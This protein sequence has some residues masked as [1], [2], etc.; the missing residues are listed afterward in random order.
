MSDIFDVLHR[1]LVH[2]DS[3]DAFD[4]FM[5]VYKFRGGKY[6]FKS[7]YELQNFYYPNSKGDED[8]TRSLLAARDGYGV[9]VDNDEY[10]VLL[11]NKNILVDHRI[12]K[13]EFRNIMGLS[14]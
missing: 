10:Q 14:E 12:S 1:N 4:E 2:L 7:L 11:N 9:L 5:N 6:V 13:E 8:N 3:N